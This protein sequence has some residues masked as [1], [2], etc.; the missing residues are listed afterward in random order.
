MP[1]HISHYRSDDD[2]RVAANGQVGVVRNELDGREYFIKVFDKFVAP[3]PEALETG[4]PAILRRQERFDAYRSRMERINARLRGACGAGAGLVT[5]KEF[6]QDGCKLV[7]VNELVDL[8]KEPAATV[9]AR[10]APVQ[11]RSMFRSALTSVQTLHGQGV[12]HA[13]I[14]PENIFICAGDGASAEPGGTGASGDGPVG[15]VGDFD[16][17]FFADEVPDAAEITSTIE[18]YSPEMAAYVSH[19]ADAD[20]PLGKGT[21]ELARAVGRAH[22]IFCLGLVYHVWLTGGMPQVI[23]GGPYVWQGLSTAGDAA[24]VL[25]PALE[26]RDAALIRWMLRADP[27]QRPATCGEVLAAMKAP[28]MLPSHT[29]SI[30]ADDGGA[31]LTGVRYRVSYAGSTGPALPERSAGPALPTGPSESAA[32]VAE[33]PGGLGGSATF[34]LPDVSPGRY[35]VSVRGRDRAGREVEATQSLV[36]AEDVPTMCFHFEDGSIASVDRDRHYLE[37]TVVDLGVEVVDD[38][39]APVCGVRVGA[40]AAEGGPAGRGAPPS[41]GPSGRAGIVG[42]ETDS[43]GRAVLCGLGRAR[44]RVRVIGEGIEPA[45]T[46]VDLG[47][48]APDARRA[49]MRVEVRRPM[50]EPEPDVVFDPPHA[51]R[52][53][54]LARVSPS[55]VRMA[56]VDGTSAVKDLRELSLYGLGDLAF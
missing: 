29:L 6:F 8:D 52:I 3:P 30:W 23:N 14:K 44:Y 34:A 49:R 21:S 24:V 36:L 35:E 48:I 15:R 27:S 38:A 11:I 50:P 56:F 55:R 17:S 12:V 20:D 10:Y 40:R 46:S 1:V 7:K 47:L 5:A 54:S 39:G 4:N 42:D 19:G 13:D 2:L 28:A 33:K 32:L 9:C 18:Y 53:A 25:D 37:K 43:R 51:G 41:G 22:D 31:Q 26:L 45:E 16:D